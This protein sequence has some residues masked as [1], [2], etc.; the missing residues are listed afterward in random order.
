METIVS[1]EE[2]TF[3]HSNQWAS[4]DGY[5]IKTTLQEIK[6]GISNGQSCC[7][8]WGYCSTLDNPEEFIGARLKEVKIT[9]TA[10]ETATFTG[11][12][13]GNT[14]FVT[15]ETSEGTF[16]LVMY[17]DHNGY[18]GHEAIVVSNKLTESEYL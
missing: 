6:V 17:N 15:I 3:T 11:E 14:M 10:L 2:C 8:Q 12:Y 16:Q 13:S 4:Y 9:N 7:E 5:I 1:I 18:Y